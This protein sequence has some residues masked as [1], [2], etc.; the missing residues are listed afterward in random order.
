MSVQVNTDWLADSLNL[1]DICPRVIERVNPDIAPAKLTNWGMGRWKDGG[2]IEFMGM[3]AGLFFSLR[4]DIAQFYMSEDIENALVNRVRRE[5][6]NAIDE[7]I[8]LVTRETIAEE[9]EKWRKGV[10]E[11]LD[12]ADKLLSEMKRELAAPARAPWWKRFTG[13][14]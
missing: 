4:V 6:G 1:K 3:W 13:S 14:V 5:V 12:R 7:R 10:S 9:I 2:D 11:P 8:A